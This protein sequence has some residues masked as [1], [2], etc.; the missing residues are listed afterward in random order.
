MNNSIMACFLNCT[1][2]LPSSS[3]RLVVVVVAA[4]AA[5]AQWLIKAKSSQSG[6]QGSVPAETT[7]SHWLLSGTSP[8]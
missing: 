1:V 7:A 4:A 6:D 5:A 3:S 8:R 2:K